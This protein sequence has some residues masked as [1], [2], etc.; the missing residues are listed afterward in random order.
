MTG[1]GVGRGGGITMQPTQSP[2]YK[3]HANRFSFRISKARLQR[4]QGRSTTTLHGM[5]FATAY[6]IQRVLLVVETDGLAT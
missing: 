2:T 3:G 4:D 5:A 1:G 6:V